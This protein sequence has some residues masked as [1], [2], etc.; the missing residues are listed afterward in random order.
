[1]TDMQTQKELWEPTLRKDHN[2]CFDLKNTR[3]VSCS[4]NDCVLRAQGQ[5]VGFIRT[6]VLILYPFDPR[7]TSAFMYEN[8]GAERLSDL[9]VHTQLVSGRA[10]SQTQSP[11]SST[12]LLAHRHIRVRGPP[13]PQSAWVTARYT[14][15]GQSNTT[16]NMEP[17]EKRSSDSKR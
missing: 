14:K 13:H 4:W 6:M 11:A 17:E 12:T 1:M 5:Q 10:R 2:L 3:R 8:T 16:E 15:E 9:A 7:T